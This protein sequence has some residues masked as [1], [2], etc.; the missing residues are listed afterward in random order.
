MKVKDHITYFYI[1][2]IK[3]WMECPVCHKKI[4][5]FK[6][7]KE[8]RCESCD[9]YLREKEFLDDYVFWFCDGCGTHLNVQKGFNRH[10]DR[11]MCTECGFYNNITKE[12]IVD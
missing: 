7:R 12:N 1:K 9:Y 5:F 8:W 6:Y 4:Y 11:W 2:R 10:K 3:R